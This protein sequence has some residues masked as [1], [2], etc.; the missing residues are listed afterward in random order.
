M[1]KKILGLHDFLHL[2]AKE[3][4][5]LLYADGV[6]V[7]KRKVGKQTVILFQLYSFYVEVFYKQYRKDIACFHT[8]ED[9]EI[10]EPYLEQIKVNNH[11]K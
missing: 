4:Y 10:L 3:Q 5:N 7:G 11:V 1:T 8:S 6:Y 9:T 2:P